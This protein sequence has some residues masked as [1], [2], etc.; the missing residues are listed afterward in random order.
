MAKLHVH[1]LGCGEAFD[2]KNG[3]TAF[4]LKQ[5]AHAARA[6]LIDCGYQIPERLWRLNQSVC[7][8]LFTHLHADHSFGIVPLLVREMEQRRRAHFTILGPRG[9]ERFVR[10]LLALGYP[11]VKL[12]FQLKFIETKPG[13]VL[14]W[15]G[16]IIESARTRHSVLNLAYLIRSGASGLLGVSGDGQM[17]ESSENLLSRSDLLFQEAYALRTTPHLHAD[18]EK[19]SRFS[20]GF[21]GRIVLTHLGRV[22]RVKISRRARSL[23]LK[24]ARMGQKFSI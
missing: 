14:R 12:G 6:L 5:V 13:T 7:G 20:Q 24:V 10:K 11:G 19:I 23:R 21:S 2:E 8:V 4:L 3:N 15:N 16:Y 17:T 22:E 9:T 1:V 18:L